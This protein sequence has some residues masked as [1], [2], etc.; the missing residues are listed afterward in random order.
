[1]E[2]IDTFLREH[3]QGKPAALIE[4]LAAFLHT[5]IQ[6]KDWRGTILQPPADVRILWAQ[7]VLQTEAYATFCE[8]YAE[9][10]FLHYRPES[11]AD[12]EAPR[13]YLTLY[14]LAAHVTDTVE[15]AKIWPVPAELVLAPSSPLLQGIKRSRV[16]R[17]IVNVTVDCTVEGGTPLIRRMRR[18]LVSAYPESHVRVLQTNAANLSGFDSYD[19]S[20]A[21]LYYRSELLDPETFVGDYDFEPGAHLDLF[22]KHE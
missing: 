20:R 7:L 3:F 11:A 17:D 2:D 10:E 12:P 15:N 5:A 9:G 1:M 19:P 18:V 14:L 16:V 4:A 6:L 21:R 22:L 13:R 8:E